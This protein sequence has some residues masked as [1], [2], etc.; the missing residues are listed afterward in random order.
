[1]PGIEEALV[2][3]LMG[4]VTVQGLVRSQI[5]PETAPQKRYTAPYLV[6]TR[7]G[8]DSVRHLR[9]AS[10]LVRTTF[11]LNVWAVDVLSRTAVNEALR[12]L[13]DGVGPVLSAGVDIRSIA[14][15][16]ELDSFLVPDDG[17][18]IGTFTTAH[19]LD[20]WHRR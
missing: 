2:A 11:S 18:E 1:M 10:G 20:I 9:G 17:S 6:Y 12:P 13:F 15:L 19:T 16:D 7:V 14:L 4:D 8:S 5:Y 3:L